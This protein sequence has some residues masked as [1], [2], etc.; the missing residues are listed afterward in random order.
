MAFESE[1]KVAKKVGI[2]VMDRNVCPLG[3]HPVKG[4]AMVHQHTAQS[5]E[6]V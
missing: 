2:D 3:L 4:T 1:T 6:M 5:L